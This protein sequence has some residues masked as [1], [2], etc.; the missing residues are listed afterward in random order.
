[1]LI[2]DL[3]IIPTPP[4]PCHHNIIEPPQPQHPAPTGSPFLDYDDDQFGLP[5]GF[6]TSHPSVLLAEKADPQ[7]LPS[8]PICPGPYLH[9]FP[10]R[11]DRLPATQHFRSRYPVLVSLYEQVVQ[12]KLPNYLGARTPVTDNFDQQVWD[13]LLQ[14]HA[15]RQVTQ[16]MLF[17]W[18][19]SFMGSTIPTL[20]LD[21]HTSS[22]VHPQAV[23]KFITKE[24]A[25]GGLIGPFSQ[26]LFSWTCRNPLMARPKKESTD[27]RIILDLSYPD[28]C[29]VNSQIPRVL[30]EG[31][32]YKLRLPMPLD[33]SE[34]IT[35]Q[36]RGALLYKVD[37]ARA[38]RQLPS[39]PYDWPLLGIGWEDNTY[40][41][42]AIPFGLRH[43]AMACQ[44]VTEAVCYAIKRKV[45]AKALP[46]IDDFGGVAPPNRTTANNRYLTL[47]T[48]ILDL[49]LSIS[50]DKCSPPALCMTWIGCTF[51]SAELTMQI[52][53]AKIVETLEMCQDFLQKQTMSLRQVEVL[54][55]K[56]LYS[57]KLADPARRFLNR[58]LQFCCD[59][60]SNT[61]L[62]I[63]EG[64]KHDL[65]WFLRFLKVYNGRA[66][67]RSRLQPSL[68]LYTDAS[69]LGGGAYIKDHQ[70]M[71]V[72]W[73]NEV[74]AWDVAIT[75]LELFTLVLALR[76]WVHFL[77]GHTVQIWS[78]NEPSIIC[79]RSGKTK[80]AFLAACLCEIWHHCS[81]SDV[82]LLY[83]HIPGSQNTIADLLSRRA[84]SPKDQ[85]NYEDFCANT[86]LQHAAVP[87]ELQYPP[88]A[89]YYW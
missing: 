56:L 79:L 5:R 23:H 26:P 65:R 42:Q 67:I 11:L 32:P 29:S 35:V 7:L 64:V 86:T 45:K 4:C 50:W 77:S 59:F 21:N 24:V 8:N 58:L 37:L 41:D 30:Y 28:Q 74:G 40:L 27:M 84:L 55:G 80:N 51:N 14:G 78:D 17:G 12:H 61:Y 18:P 81:V 63:P 62:P 75:E 16:F 39:N 33:L 22:L 31:A 85:H 34:L 9:L 87:D 82:D 49:G 10:P 13:D 57:S 73:T 6:L 89:Y 72:L 2:D 68:H 71:D 20:D 52:E 15:D 53:E 83:S 60:S 66:L 1:M 54:L 25:L 38:Y 36:G 46:Y 3:M 88:D 48:V 69:L 76:Y 43:G 44:R 47:K 70:F 19:T